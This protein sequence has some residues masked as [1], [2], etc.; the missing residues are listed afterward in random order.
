M[1]FFN[2]HCEMNLIEVLH[3]W[4][5]ALSR[6]PLVTPTTGIP[7]FTLLMWGHKNKIEEGKTV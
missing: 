6:V 5:S 7:R 1:Y 2:F 4:T 3:C